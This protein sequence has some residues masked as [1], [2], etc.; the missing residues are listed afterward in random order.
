MGDRPALPVSIGHP[1]HGWVVKGGSQVV[2][3][4]EQVSGRGG[5][6]VQFEQTLGGQV[7][8]GSGG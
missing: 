1:C 5:R 2:E 6:F 4:G 8:K 7:V 3:W